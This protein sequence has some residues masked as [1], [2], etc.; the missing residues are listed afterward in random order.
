MKVYLLGIKTFIVGRYAGLLVFLI[1]LIV[2]QPFVETVIG[3]LLV[4]ALFV[5]AMVAGLR[6]IGVRA[7][8][9]NIE[10]MLLIAS[11]SCTYLGA[12][13][14]NETVFTMGLFGAALFLAVVAITIL[15]NLFQSKVITGDTLAGAVCVYLLIALVWGYLFLL[16]EFWFPESFSFTQ[17]HERVQLWLAKEFYPFFYFSLVTMTTVGYGDMAPVSTAART[18]A[19]MEALLGQVYLTI[20]VARLV[21]MYLVHQQGADD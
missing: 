11:L 13:L 8:L 9:R 7:S 4:E 1:C 2:F 18:C 5:G 3:K 15:V 6:A 10:I 12:F 21:G 19:T 14:N 17:G 20:L 16:V